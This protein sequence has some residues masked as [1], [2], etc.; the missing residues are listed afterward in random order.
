MNLIKQLFSST[1]TNLD[2]TEIKAKLESENP[3]ILLDVRQSDEYRAGHISGAMLIP[4]NQ[5]GQ[6]LSELPKEREIVCVCR[7]GSRSGMANRMLTEAG[8]NSFNLRG[9]MIAWSR[10]G[11]PSQQGN[12]P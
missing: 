2:A 12:T 1:T 9:G 6:R 4:L 5:L 11:L 7:S 3:P 10:A 8:F